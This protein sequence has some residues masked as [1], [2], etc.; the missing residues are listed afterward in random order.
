[1]ELRRWDNRKVIY[2]LECDSYKELLKS[3]I[4][5]DVSL[6]KAD[7]KNIDLTNVNLTSVY[8]R[9]AN[10]TGV[11]LT[12][13]NLTDAYLRHANLTGVN[14][15]NADLTN[16]NLTNA[17]LTNTKGIDYFKCYHLYTYKS[18]ILKQTGK[19][20][21]V[22]MGC[23]EKT[24]KESD[25]NFWNNDRE[26]PNNGSEHSIDRLECYKIMINDYEEF[27]KG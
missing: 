6:Y 2:E 16:A 21:R 3:A 26:F 19:E 10:L 27:N 22:R 24:I 23:F 18:Y 17:N 20:P 14:L 7:L 1:M 11:N 25:S 8:L 12:N 4:E 5:N 13:A 9:H 15:T